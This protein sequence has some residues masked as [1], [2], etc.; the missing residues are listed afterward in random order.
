MYVLCF[1]VH[2]TFTLMETI[3]QLYY[4]VKVCVHYVLGLI[5][6]VR[7]K[8]D[9]VFGNCTQKICGMYLVRVISVTPE[10][11]SVCLYSVTT[12]LVALILYYAV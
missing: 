4:G 1:S 6:P 10:C 12:V 11:V 7:T 9:T 5:L 3:R 2:I 8:V